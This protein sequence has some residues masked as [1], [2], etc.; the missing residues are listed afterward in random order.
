[1]IVSSMNISALDHVPAHDP[2][3]QC[4]EMQGTEVDTPG[5]FASHATFYKMNILRSDR[6]QEIPLEPHPGGPDK[7]SA[8]DYGLG[9]GTY[10]AGD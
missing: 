8:I 6:V 9:E 1:M 2:P 7:I 10:P 5:Q 3:F 4:R